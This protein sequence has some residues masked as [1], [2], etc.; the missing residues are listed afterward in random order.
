MIVALALAS[1]CISTPA[2]FAQ[3]SAGYAPPQT[4]WGTPDLGGFWSNTSLTAMQRPAGADSL[5]LSEADAEK[6]T[7]H[8]V[9]SGAQREEAGA[10]KVDEASSKK[11]LSDGNASRAYNRFWMDPGESYAKVKGEYR[12]SWITYPKDGRI[13]YS[14]AGMRANTRT[15]SFDDFEI[16]PLS[17]RCIMSFTGGAG[18]V[19]N[20]GMYNNTYQFV[21][22]KDYVLI[23]VEMNHDA[24]IIPLGDAKMD[25]YQWLGRSKGRWDGDTLVVETTNFNPG[26]SLRTFFSA[27]YLLSPN[28]K[29]TERFSR[30]SDAE[31][32]YEF[33]VDDPTLFSQPWKAEMVFNRSPKPA[34][35]YACH[36]GNHALP[37]ILAGARLNDSAGVKNYADESE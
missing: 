28:G 3:A 23:N 36:E 1:T 6:L 35:E 15:N 18:P 25:V 4:S 31:I 19:M 30:V 33:T 32:L 22:T 11:L 8:N 26:E 20:N 2:C 34:Y 12:S 16:R 9:Y 5:V 17:E 21:Q 10:S 29:V 13:P 7:R 27:S 14:N 24:R 37:G